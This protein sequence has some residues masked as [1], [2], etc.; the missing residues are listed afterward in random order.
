MGQLAAQLATPQE[1][2]SRS[3]RSIFRRQQQYQEQQSESPED[4]D[5]RLASTGMTSFTQDTS[6]ID[7]NKRKK[8]KVSNNE[9]ENSPPPQSSSSII[10]TNMNEL[11]D[12]DA[13]FTSFATFNT[14]FTVIPS[15]F[16]WKSIYI[17]SVYAIMGSTIRSF[18][19]R[20]FGVDCE[21]GN[22]QD[23]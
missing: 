7:P 22:V 19:S 6:T 10:R 16:D 13:T 2:P 3:G 8:K 9:E 12:G 4:Y 20:S 1:K 21:V 18:L 15:T 14:L 5:L 23:F 17:F 11:T